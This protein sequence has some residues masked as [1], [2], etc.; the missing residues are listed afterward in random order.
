VSLQPT[1]R[2][3]SSAVIAELSWGYGVPGR[4]APRVKHSVLMGLLMDAVLNNVAWCA[5]VSGPGGT[6]DTVLAVWSTVGAPP[7]LFPDAVTLRPGVSAT[8]LGDVVADRRTRSVKDS[9]ADVDLEPYGS[10]SLFVARWLGRPSPDAGNMK[11]WTTVADQAGLASWCSAAE[12]PQALPV[13]LLGD[14]SVTVLAARLHGHLSSGAMLTRG[15][16]V[17]GLS[18]VF[19]ED[20]DSRSI[21]YDLLAVIGRYA[22]GL[23]VVGYEHGANRDAALDAGSDDPGPLRVW[24]RSPDK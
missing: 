4:A 23:P 2:I 10:R 14:C 20:G 8:D 17:V 12:L 1:S 3:A 13:A 15:A 18:N 7:P 6:H 21:W 19:A 16:G 24:T 22:P 9:F 11:E 5:W